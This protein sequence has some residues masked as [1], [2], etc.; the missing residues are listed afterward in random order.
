MPT[1]PLIRGTL[2]LLIL[3]TLVLG[4]LTGFEITSR[5]EERSGGALDVEDSALYQ[6]LHRM[7]ARGLIEADWGISERNRRARYYRLTRA[8]R[9][10]LRAE[11]SQWIAAARLVVD[12][13][14]AAP[15]TA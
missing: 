10:Y 3:K 14:S 12:I 15:D 11:S 13:L 9:A 5:L 4:P 6:A 1:S 8:G 2:D 7:E